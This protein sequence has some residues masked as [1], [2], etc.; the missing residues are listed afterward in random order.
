MS[1]GRLIVA[2]DF[3]TTSFRSLVTEITPNGDLEIVGCAQEKVEGFQDGD[4]VDLGAGARCIAR[5]IR[6]LEA[7]SDIYVS[8]FT[9]N[10]AGSHLHSVRATAQVSIG[11]GPRPI[12]QRDVDEVIKKA[13]SMAI[14]FD[15]KILT[16]TPVE[17]SVDR[18][19]GILDPLGRVG[20]LLE[21]T[22]H[23]V[24]GSRSVLNNIE[25]VVETAKYK[26]LGEEVDVMAASVAL[27]ETQ[28][29]E[30]GVMLIDIGGDITNWAIYRKGAILTN[31]SIPWGG[32]NMTADLAHGLRV[33]W[34]EAEGIKRQRGVVMRNQVAEVSLSA[35]FEEDRPESTKG[36]IAAILEPRMEEI[37]TLVKK[38]FGD[39]QELASLGAGVVLTGGG[40]RCRGTSS[41][42]EEIFDL[43]ARKRYLPR[44][45]AG[46]DQLP[47]GQWA[48]VIGLCRWS[49]RD[50]AQAGPQEVAGQGG[51]LLG[52]LRGMFNR[53]EK[54]DEMVAKG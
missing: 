47:E 29:M 21:I 1:Q 19:R 15:Q 39:L 13:R 45:L 10:I 36:L 38:D 6:D 17:Y 42:C 11:P 25:N 30:Q 32:N 24:T 16:V 27:L 3:G 20:S 44:K 23:L 40:S 9:Y 28:E 41:L 2:C 5:C 31:G 22:A 50:V 33:P 4:F 34:E 53:T 46:A 35:L 18:V 7:D 49:A 43:Q 26:P 37:L 14:P 48:T 51:G 54:N 12:R 52:K 8:G